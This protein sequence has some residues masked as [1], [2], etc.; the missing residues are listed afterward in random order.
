MQKHVCLVQKTKTKQNRKQQILTV[1]GCKLRMKG[2][3]SAA[4]QQHKPSFVVFVCL[5]FRRTGQS[6]II[7][8]VCPNRSYQ[9]T[10]QVYGRPGVSDH[11][12][13][14]LQPAF[15]PPLGAERHGC[16]VGSFPKRQKTDAR[17]DKEVRIERGLKFTWESRFVPG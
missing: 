3:N 12:L 16:S 2:R 6:L 4:G 13:Q 7:H 14:L 15:H 17:R 9:Q 10:F 1:T 5:A 11:V 8:E